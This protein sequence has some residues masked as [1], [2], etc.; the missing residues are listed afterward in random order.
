MRKNSL[1]GLCLAVTLFSAIKSSAQDLMAELNNDLPKQKNY[2]FATFKSTRLIDGATVECLGQG[3]LDF[4]ISHRFGDVSQGLSDFYGM[5][6]ALTRLSLDYGVNKWLMVGIAHNVFD[7]EDNGDIKIKLLRQQIGGGSPVTVSYFGSISVQTTPA[8]TLPD[9]TY[10]WLFSNRLYFANQILIGRKF[11]KTFSFQLM[12]TLVHY[13]LVDSSKFSN[14][15]FALGAGFRW[16]FTRSSAVTAEYY[17]RLNNTN[18]LVQGQPTYNVFSIGYEVE[19]GGHVFQVMLTN[20]QGLTERTFIGQTTQSWSKQ[21][22][23]LGF[24]ISRVFT[25][26]KPKGYVAPA[27]DG[28]DKKW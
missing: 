23:H 24:N 15:T 28:D 10:K 1:I 26:V 5:D 7:K 3:V 9:S 22:L 20:A 13:N 8:P 14:N 6:N 4:R 19:T 18:M 25:I 11:S 2:A 12:P 21:Q 27:K 16:M 17:Y